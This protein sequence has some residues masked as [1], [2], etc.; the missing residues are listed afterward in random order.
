[1][2]ELWLTSLIEGSLIY[3]EHFKTSVARNQDKNKKKQ[4][5]KK[6]NKQKITKQKNLN[7]DMKQSTSKIIFKKRKKMGYKLEVTGFKYSLYQ[8]VI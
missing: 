4:F 3:S 5:C 2:C 6:I 8:Y 1:M 7:K